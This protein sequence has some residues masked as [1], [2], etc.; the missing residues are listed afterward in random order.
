M[1]KALYFLSLAACMVLLASC[2]KEKEEAEPTPV[3]AELTMFYTPAFEAGQIDS[4]WNKI[5]ITIKGVDIVSGSYYFDETKVVDASG[6]PEELVKNKGV[7]LTADQLGSVNSAEGL[8]IIKENL[9]EETDYKTVLVV[10]NSAGSSKTLVETFTTC[11][12]PPP[13]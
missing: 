1:K 13:M 8:L 5:A 6:T 10:S 2:K 7:K 11:Q 3:E 4:D 9:K 12:V